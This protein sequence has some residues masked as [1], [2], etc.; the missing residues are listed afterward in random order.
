MDARAIVNRP[1]PCNKLA[2]TF[3]PRSGQSKNK[4]CCDGSRK[5]AGVPTRRPKLDDTVIEWRTDR[6]T[7]ARY[8]LGHPRLLDIDA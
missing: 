8:P 2:D 5:N 4:P 1:L 7:T 3:P 6:R